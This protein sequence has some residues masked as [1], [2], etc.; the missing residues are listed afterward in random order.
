MDDDVGCICIAPRTHKEILILIFNTLNVAHV[1]IYT[2]TRWACMFKNV[3]DR[4]HEKLGV[5]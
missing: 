4:D 2:Y 3:M 1:M 5:R